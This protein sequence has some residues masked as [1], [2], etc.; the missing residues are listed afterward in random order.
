MIL[1]LKRRS[2]TSAM[3]GPTVTF[4]SNSYNYYFFLNQVWPSYWYVWERKHNSKISEMIWKLGGKILAIWQLS[5]N[6][7]YAMLSIFSICAWVPD[8]MRIQ[9]PMF[10]PYNSCYVASVQTEPHSAGRPVHSAEYLQILFMDLADSKIDFYA[11]YY[12][13]ELDIKL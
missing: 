6:P 13:Q 5:G 4:N 2:E 11:S 1:D 12:P 7:T 9:F 8:I 3:N 10:P